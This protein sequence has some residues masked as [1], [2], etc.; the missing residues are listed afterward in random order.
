M[1]AETIVPKTDIYSSYGTNPEIIGSAGE[2]TKVN[3]LG[4]YGEEASFLKVNIDEHTDAYIKTADCKIT[5]DG[6]LQNHS[7]KII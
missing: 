4:W 5:Q 2:G 6:T 3:I 7:I 1:T